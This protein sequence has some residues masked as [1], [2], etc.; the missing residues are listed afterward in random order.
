MTN[1]TDQPVVKTRGD[2]VSMLEIA[3]TVLRNW[4]VI[5]VLPLVLAFV[6]GVYSLSR[7]RMYTVDASFLPQVEGAGGAASLAQQFGVSLG[8][9]RPG[10]QP[11]F[12]VDLMKSPAILRKLVESE[13]SIP[14][15]DGRAW[16]GTLIQ[17]LKLEGNGITAWRNATRTMQN[18][19]T[20]S[21]NPK[22]GVVNMTVIADD[23]ALVEGIAARLLQLL[24]D[25]NLQVRQSR[26][27]EEDRFI[28]GRM[29]D[30][31]AELRSA[32]AALQEFLRHNRAFS[33]SPELVF[34][35]DRLQRN[36][37]MRQEV[38]TSLLRSQEQARID[39]IRD[40][41]TFTVIDHPEG[42]AGPKGRRTVLRVVLAFMLGLMIA[43]F[44]AFIAEAARRGRELQD[45][46]YR[47]FEGLFHQTVRD[48]LRPGRWWRGSPANR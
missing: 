40:T 2:E 47:E 18:W 9:E 27:Q 14:G 33:N 8:T 32:E 10:Q 20:S 25:F 34:D 36:V 46:E 41:R 39:A 6:A 28:T 17:H 13:Y 22:T 3:N 43:S 48:V 21:V 30:A 37:I 1:P 19:I 42:A 23:P 4:R 5:V 38:Y 31:Q 24:N 15:K 29:R 44:V 26:A 11:Q 35:H 45:P 12:Y 16:N 7:D